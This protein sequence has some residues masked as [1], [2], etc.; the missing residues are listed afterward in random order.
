MFVWEKYK[1]LCWLSNWVQRS[2]Q[3]NAGSGERI[4]ELRRSTRQMQSVF[5]VRSWRLYNVYNQQDQK[6]SSTIWS[7]IKRSLSGRCSRS[8]SRQQAHSS[9]TAGS[10]IF[11]FFL[12]VSKTSRRRWNFW[13][14]VSKTHLA[15][16]Q[17]D[18][19]SF[20]S[21]GSFNC[22]LLLPFQAEIDAFSF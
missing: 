2:I 14:P 18:L 7:T 19:R 16:R 1:T 22:L 4:A 20:P 8:N 13:R 6:P 11:P 12:L 17:L 21:D 10:M 3:K 9:L 15:D 5:K